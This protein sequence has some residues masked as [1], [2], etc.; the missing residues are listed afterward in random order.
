MNNGF[1][2]SDWK[3]F[4]AMLPEVREKY[5]VILCQKFSQ[6]LNEAEVTAT[7][8]FWSTYQSMEKHQ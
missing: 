3:K 7:D 1:K 2:K 6:D 4:T 5:L 8:R